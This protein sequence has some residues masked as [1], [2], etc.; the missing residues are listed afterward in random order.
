MLNFFIFASDD[1]FCLLGQIH[2]L[3]LHSLHI[4]HLLVMKLLISP[5]IAIL[6]NHIKL[7]LPQSFQCFPL[8]DFSEY[9]FHQV[10]TNESSW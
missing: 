6:D 10:Y 9:I 7:K 8:F 1:I 4:H 3:L 2:H 5:L